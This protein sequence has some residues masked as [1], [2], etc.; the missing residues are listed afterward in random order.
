[1]ALGICISSIYSFRVQLMKPL[2][3]FCMYLKI[4]ATIGVAADSTRYL[5]QQ[6]L[7]LFAQTNDFLTLSCMLFELS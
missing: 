5:H 1:M 6:H 4:P 2:P 7:S 3:M